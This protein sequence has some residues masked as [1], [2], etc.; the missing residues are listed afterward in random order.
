MKASELFHLYIWLID[1]IYRYNHI[2]LESLNEK[3]RRTSMSGGIAMSRSTFNR[4]RA[5]IEEMFDLN[6][7]CDRHTNCY[8]IDNSN[9]RNDGGIKKWMLDTISV[10]SMVSE[11]KNMKD[12]ILLE[13]VP[14]GQNHLT[15]ITSAMQSQHTIEITY[16]KFNEQPKVREVEPYCLKLYHQRWYLLGHR[17]DKGYLNIFALDRITSVVD[18]DKRF[19]MDANF[20]ARE[21]FR[22]YFGVMV[23][24]EE[25]QKVVLRTSVQQANYYRTLPFHSSQRETLRTPD[26]VEFTL[27]IS[28]SYDFRQEL[29]AQGPNITVVEPESLRQQIIESLKKNLE[30]YL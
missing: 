22:P 21:Y 23:G 7:E 25:P 4:Y 29:L 20:N 8:Y 3:W 28:P 30:N 17:T 14:S 1:T 18:T 12:R 2:T 24:M 27:H 10:G 6:I 11:S 5:S 19:K 13:D 9:R 26:F 15:A 16:H